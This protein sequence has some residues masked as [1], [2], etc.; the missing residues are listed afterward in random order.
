MSLNK[1][2][3]ASKSGGMGRIS[4]DKKYAQVLLEKDV[5]DEMEKRAK[6]IGFPSFS[7]WAGFVLKRELKDPKHFDV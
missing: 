4:D 6:E 3:S 1:K 2:K 5:Y 7:A